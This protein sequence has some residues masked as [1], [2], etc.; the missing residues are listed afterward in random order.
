[1]K[2]KAAYLKYYYQ[3]NKGLLDIRNKAYALAHPDKN[4]VYTANYRKNNAEKRVLSNILQRCNNP[5]NHAY[6]HYGGRGIKCFITSADEIIAAIG[7]KPSAF[8]SIDRI[9]N[10][11]P[12]KI[13]NIRWAT[14]KEQSVNR[15][16]SRRRLAA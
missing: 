5:L 15:R 16:N 1:M 8:H 14:A 13:G 4:K 12:Y 3:K 6:R 10:D 11:G 2:D 9:D 7:K